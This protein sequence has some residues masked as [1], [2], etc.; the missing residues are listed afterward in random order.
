MRSSSRFFGIGSPF[1]TSGVASLE[2]SAHFFILELY[3][4]SPASLV[5]QSL[6]MAAAL[7]IFCKSWAASVS[8]FSIRSP[9]AHIWTYCMQL[10]VR[11]KKNVCKSTSPE[12]PSLGPYS[13]NSWN[14]FQAW[15]IPSSSPC[16]KVITCLLRYWTLLIGNNF[17][18]NL[19]VNLFQLPSTSKDANEN[20][21]FASPRS[22]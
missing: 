22:A 3:P 19:F 18:Q 11:E 6:R 15:S 16:M 13:V 9:L 12:K 4:V 14:L 17:S 20:H 5:Y 7:L 10:G 1:V 8:V 2:I 21:V